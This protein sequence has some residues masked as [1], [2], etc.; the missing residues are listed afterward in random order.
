MPK[1][2][3]IIVHPDERLVGVVKITPD[4]RLVGVVKITPE[5]E[6]IVR[7]LCRQSGLSARYLVSEIIKQG[8]DLVEFISPEESNP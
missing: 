8:A 7:Q 5:A 1:P 4:E 6:R 2:I 3:Q